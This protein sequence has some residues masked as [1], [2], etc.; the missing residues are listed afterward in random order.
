MGP[1]PMGFQAFFILLS[2]IL[3]SFFSTNSTLLSHFEDGQPTFHRTIVYET[4]RTSRAVNNLS[5]GWKHVKSKSPTPRNCNFNEQCS[6]WALVWG[7]SSWNL[8]CLVPFPLE[9]QP[10]KI[11][12][13]HLLKLLRPSWLIKLLIVLAFTNNMS[14]PSIKVASSR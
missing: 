12:T 14:N 13:S 7:K 10:L 11:T 6:T 9:T 8:R 5:I 2:R 3:S 1:K 4:L